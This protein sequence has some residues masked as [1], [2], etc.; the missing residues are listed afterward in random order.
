MELRGKEVVVTPEPLF[1]KKFKEKTGV[2]VL[3]VDA[4]GP[5]YYQGHLENFFEC[6]RTRKKPNLDAD[7]GYKAMVAIGLGVEAYREQKQMLFDPATERILKNG[8][9]RETFE[10]DGKNVDETKA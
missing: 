5:D 7:F 4:T 8:L 9:K 3:Q 10:G 2:D 6:M 1:K